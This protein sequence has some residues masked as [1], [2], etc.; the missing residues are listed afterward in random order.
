M[1]KPNS[2]DFTRREAAEYLGVSVATLNQ[3]AWARKNLPYTLMGGQAW[4]RRADC[5]HLLRR[6]TRKVQA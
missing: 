4:Y 3:W 1:R 5:E 6:N 2:Y